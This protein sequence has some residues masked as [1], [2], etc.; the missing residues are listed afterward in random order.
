MSNF[1]YWFLGT[2]LVL[3]CANTV[4]QYR[5][6][7]KQGTQAGYSVGMLHSIKWLMKNEALEV[8]NKTTGLP[9]TPAEVV[10]HIMN[11]VHTYPNMTEEEADLIARASVEH[12][13]N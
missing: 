11:K 2:M 3:F 10:V 6:G 4:I 9:A 12:E 8:E 7:F 1:D 13:K 5:Y